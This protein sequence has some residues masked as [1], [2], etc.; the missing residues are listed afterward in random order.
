MQVFGEDIVDAVVNEDILVTSH[1]GGV[2]NMYSLRW[3]VEH[4]TVVDASLGKFVEL[5]REGR[6]GIR[7]G[8]VGSPGFGIPCTVKLTGKGVWQGQ[9]GAWQSI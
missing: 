6:G 9:G 1:R 2:V 7:A 4:C 3:I 5:P 8:S